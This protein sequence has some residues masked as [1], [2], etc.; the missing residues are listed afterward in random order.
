MAVIDAHAHLEPR[1]LSLPELI[2][3]MDATGIDRCALIATINDPLPATPE[4]LL[5]IL[6]VM[7]DSRRLHPLARVLSEMFYTRQGDLRLRGQIYRIYHTPDNQPVA[8]ALRAH[9]DR[10]LGWIFLNPGATENAVEELERWRVEP[11]FI[12]VKLHPY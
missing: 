4:R 1:M 11:G 6:R 5:A 12:G 7:M 9:P 8:D 3:K 10:L 2:A